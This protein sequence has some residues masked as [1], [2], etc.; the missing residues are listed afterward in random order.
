VCAGVPEE[1]SEFKY[2]E[3]E[4]FF[5]LWSRINDYFSN[6]LKMLLSSPV[7]ELPGD[8]IGAARKIIASSNA[9]F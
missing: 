1:G 7:P 8:D 6:I 9:K 3:S 2:F 4:P 5:L